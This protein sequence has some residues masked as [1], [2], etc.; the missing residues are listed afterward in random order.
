[1]NSTE[2]SFGS[3]LVVWFLER[4]PMFHPRVLLDAPGVR[5]PRLRWWA[6]I[7]VHHDGREGGNYFTSV[8]RVWHHMP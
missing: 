7:L 2:F 6:M 1:M 8:A 4:V 3:I 5:E